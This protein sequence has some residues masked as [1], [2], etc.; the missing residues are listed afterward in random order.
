LILNWYQCEYH[1]RA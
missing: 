1:S